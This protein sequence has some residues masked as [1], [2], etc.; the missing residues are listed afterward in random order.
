MCEALGR[1][2]FSNVDISVS[3][4]IPDLKAR[5]V[6][7]V[8]NGARGLRVCV[9][10]VSSADHDRAVSPDISIA[11]KPVGGARAVMVLN[12]IVRLIVMSNLFGCD[13]ACHLVSFPVSRRPFIAMPRAVELGAPAVLFCNRTR[14]RRQLALHA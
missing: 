8:C 7:P 3:L 14:A 13:E 5:Y 4:V 10:S 2:P 12:P 1:I 9:G 11:Y 6:R